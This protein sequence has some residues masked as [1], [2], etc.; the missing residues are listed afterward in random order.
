MSGLECAVLK[1]S[2]I[3]CALVWALFGL[4]ALPAISRAAGTSHARAK[5]LFREGNSRYDRGDYAGALERYRQARALY[6]IGLLGDL[7]AE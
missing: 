6:P 4:C 3:V 2:V 5:A 7:S 1:S